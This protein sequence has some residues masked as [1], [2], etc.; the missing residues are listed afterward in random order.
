[1]MGEK[2]VKELPIDDENVI[3]F[4]DKTYSLSKDKFCM[5]E[6][7]QQVFPK[8]YMK[9]H[10]AIQSFEVFDDDVWLCTFP[11]SGLLS[12]QLSQRSH[13]FVY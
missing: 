8:G 10:G 5:I 7:Y 1:M 12:F 2:T 4:C 13:L 11:K 9:H 3:R 6:P